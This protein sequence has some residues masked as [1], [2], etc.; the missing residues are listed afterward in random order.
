MYSIFFFKSKFKSHR[1][2][3]DVCLLAGGADPAVRHDRVLQAVVEVV[4]LRGGVVRGGQLH[5]LAP[6]DCGEQAVLWT[7][8]R[9]TNGYKWRIDGY[10]LVTIGIN[11]GL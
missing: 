6:G 7:E 8:V 1:D 4:R 2:G 10:K 11:K 3:G 5:L 9:F